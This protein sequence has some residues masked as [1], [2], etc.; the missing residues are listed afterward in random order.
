MPVEQCS[1]GKWRIGDGECVYTTERAA[2][3]AYQAYLAIEGESAAEHEEKADANRISF[4]FDDTLEY[5]KVQAIAERYMTEG[6]T[7][8]VITRRQSE[9]SAEVYEVTDELGIPRRRV[10]FTN[11]QMKWETV[12][13]LNIGHH[14][15]NNE[16]EIRLIRENTDARATLVNDDQIEDEEGMSDDEMK[17]IVNAI[18]HKE[19]TYNDYPEAATNNAK[20]ALKWKEENGSTCGTPV[21]W[22]RANQLAN[23]ERI[24]RDTIARMASFKRHQQN[25]DVPYSEGCGGIMWDAWGGTAGIEWAIRKLR[26]IDE[27]KTSMIYGYKR[28]TQEVKDVDA[29]KGIVTG[30]FSAFNIK[31]SDGDIIVPGAFQKSLSEWFPKGRIKHLLNHDPRQPLGKLMDLKEDSYG[32]YYESQIGTHN[33]GRDFIKMVES[34]L[35]KEHSIGFNVKGSRKGKDAT[36]LYDVVLYEGSSLT[37][38]GANEYTPMLGLKSMDARIE[39]VKK[40][41]KFIKHTSATDETI[42]LLMLEIKQLNQLIEDLSNQPAVEETP[43]EPKVESEDVAQKAANALDI[44]LL[45]YF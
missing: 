15:D 6:K 23:R 4:D 13:R 2:T 44:L 1:N 12:Q 31:D 25:K 24:S 10:I 35:V 41:E 11:G 36:E 33:L 22:T 38:W 28:M 7:V 32:L 27:K 30:Y 40:L 17:H 42:E 18:M 8:Y 19:E 26:Q 20:R 37:S 29:K 43:A 5:P 16:D 3:R 39:R 45:K 9:D 14:Y 21:G 34:D